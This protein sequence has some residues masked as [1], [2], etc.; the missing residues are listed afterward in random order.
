ME[1]QRQGHREENLNRECGWLKGN[2]LE[3][4]G[5]QVAQP[6]VAG[7]PMGNGSSQEASIK[8]YLQGR[9]SLEMLVTWLL[10]TGCNR[11]R[12]ATLSFL[13][14][15]GGC[16]LLFPARWREVPNHLPS[17]EH[18]HLTV[19]SAHSVSLQWLYHFPSLR[20]TLISRRSGDTSF[21]GSQ[22]TS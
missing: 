19:F 2:A 10:R 6:A 4:S 17:G 1:A 5:K 22:W 18:G 20:P 7:P 11:Y 15:S 12:G 3:Y 16:C 14:W 21:G 9:Y 8:P 13:P